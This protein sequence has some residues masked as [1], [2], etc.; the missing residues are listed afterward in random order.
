LFGSSTR[1]RHARRI[2]RRTFIKCVVHD[3][4]GQKNGT[5]LYNCRFS[6]TSL[7]LRVIFSVSY[8]WNIFGSFTEPFRQLA[9]PAPECHTILDFVGARDDGCSSDSNRNSKT[10]KAPAKSSP[11]SHQH[12]VV[13]GWMPCLSP[14][15]QCHITE[16]MATHCNNRKGKITHLPFT[17]CWFMTRVLTTSAGVPSIADVSPEQALK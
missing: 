10:C 14:S 1:D 13:T 3:D 9:K 7:A 17:Y 5:T 16:G 2:Y 6:A 11:P 8:F 4:L 15:Q 12:T